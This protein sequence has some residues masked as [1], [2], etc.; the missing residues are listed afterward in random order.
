MFKLN[1]IIYIIYTKLFRE[2]FSDIFFT[3]LWIEI[4]LYNYTEFFYLYSTRRAHAAIR[5]EFEKFYNIR[6]DCAREEKVCRY[7]RNDQKNTRWFYL[8]ISVDAIHIWNEQ[9]KGIRYVCCVCRVVNLPSTIFSSSFF[10]IQFY[11][12]SFRVN[13]H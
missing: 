3:L 1:I 11:N 2:Y 4:L 8:S 10:F 5:R 13:C 7:F 12:N 6:S 9:I